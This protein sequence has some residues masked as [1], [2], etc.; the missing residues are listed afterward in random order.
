MPALDIFSQFFDSCVG[1]W[2]SER[3]YH[4]L[5]ESSVERSHTHF[6]V[7]PISAEHKAKVFADNRYRGSVDQLERC[8]GL[9]LSFHTI[10]EKGEV[11]D[12]AVNFVLVPI[13]M[14][15][16]E[17]GIVEGDYLRDRSYEDERSIV[18]DFRF[19]SRTRELLTTSRYGQVVSVDSITLLTPTMRARRIVNYKR[20]SEGEPLT[21]IDLLGLGIEN[22]VAKGKQTEKQSQ[23]RKLFTPEVVRLYGI[24]YATSLDEFQR[25]K[26]QAKP[27]GAE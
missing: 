25:K 2:N 12:R 27:S 13:D 17:E 16:K 1:S 10:S 4:Y 9:H 3:T 23:M 14:P 6:S 21:E 11:V 26:Q 20:P 5:S 15:K 7:E 18:T 19:D 8:P 24:E 22:K